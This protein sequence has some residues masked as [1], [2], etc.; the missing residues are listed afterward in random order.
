MF[1]FILA[2]KSV[3]VCRH[4]TRI[5]MI[6]TRYLIGLFYFYTAD[7]IHHADTEAPQ[8]RSLEWGM[9]TNRGLLASDNEGGG[10]WDQT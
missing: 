3:H 1:V 8:T 6:L 2:F 9:D 7:N 10:D 4:L 5:V